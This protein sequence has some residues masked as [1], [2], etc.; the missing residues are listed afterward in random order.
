MLKTNK[1]N[2]CSIKSAEFLILIL[3]ET[4]KDP[5]IHIQTSSYFRSVEKMLLPYITIMMIFSSVLVDANVTP[6]AGIGSRL[7][8]LETK[9]KSQ[10][11][12]LEIYQA[13]GEDVEKLGRWF[14]MTAGLANP[15]S[16]DALEKLKNESCNEELHSSPHLTVG[17][18]NMCD[19]YMEADMS[20]MNCVSSLF[21]DRRRRCCG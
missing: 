2:E 11:L 7:Q 4:S 21:L 16:A 14:C 20:V 15:S 5:H 6:K 8:G 1:R 12:K 3:I 17:L 19:A 10:V 13:A 18:I 9:E